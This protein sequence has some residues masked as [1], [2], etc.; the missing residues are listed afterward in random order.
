LHTVAQEY[1]WAAASVGDMRFTQDGHVT[2]GWARLVEVMAGPTWAIMREATREMREVDLAA[3]CRD[4]EKPAAKRVASALKKF[5]NRTK[6]QVASKVPNATDTLVINMF[7]PMAEVLQTT[8]ARQIN[9][10]LEE[11]EQLMMEA[12]EWRLS[13]LDDPDKPAL[14]PRPDEDTDE[15]GTGFGGG[16]GGLGLGGV[17]VVA[18]RGRLH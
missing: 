4:A 12:E 13:L 5:V 8:Y 6:K 15:D 2:G 17:A 10:D 1:A 3:R 7:Q 14:G 16:S 11:L 9:K 18:S